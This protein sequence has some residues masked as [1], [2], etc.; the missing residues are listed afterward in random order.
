MAIPTC[1]AACTITIPAINNDRCGGSLKSSEITA[2]YVADTGMTDWTDSAEWSSKLNQAGG[3]TNIIKIEG[4][5][6]L[7]EPEREE[8]TGLFG[9]TKLRKGTY[10]LE[11][12]TD[13]LTTENVTAARTFQCGEGARLIG[14]ETDDEAEIWGYSEQDITV[15]INA[16]IVM[17]GG[18]EAAQITYSMS[19]ESKF[20]PEF[21]AKPF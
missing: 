4:S 3:A 20:A 18:T 13:I 12:F 21:I 11:G 16:D 17:P 1:P 14:F 15:T 19:W 9:R 8:I 5:F 6:T 10:T 2:I 7:A